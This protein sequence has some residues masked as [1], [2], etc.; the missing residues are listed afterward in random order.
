VEFIAPPVGGT[1]GIRSVRLAGVLGVTVVPT[2]TPAR[3]ALASLRGTEPLGT[4]VPPATAASAPLLRRTEP[5][6][7]LSPPP[8]PLPPLLLKTLPICWS[9]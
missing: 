6:D 3:F 7:E 9:S 1:E 2:R 4:V 8:P 5:L